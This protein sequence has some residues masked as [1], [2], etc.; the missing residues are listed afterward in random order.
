MSNSSVGRLGEEKACQYL[1]SQNYSLL[2]R[3][4]RTKLGEL[5][6]VAKKNGIITFCEVKTRIGDAKGKPYEAVDYRKLKH[7]YNACQL[8]IL[9]NNIKSAKLSLQVISIELHPDMSVQSI[10]MY[11]VV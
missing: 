3:N 10:R 6:I 1:L 5:D 4:Y 7:L 8:Y 9:Q 2:A 11:E